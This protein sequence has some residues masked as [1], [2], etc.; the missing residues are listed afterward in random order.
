[1]TVPNDHCLQQDGHISLCT[2]PCL[3]CHTS[4]DQAA[5][6]PQTCTQALHRLCKAVAVA[7]FQ[8]QHAVA[9]SALLLLDSAPANDV[10]ACV[11]GQCPSP[12]GPGA[13]CTLCVLCCKAKAGEADRT[14]GRACTV[15]PCAAAGLIVG[16]LCWRFGKGGP[17]CPG[18]MHAALA[19]GLSRPA[20]MG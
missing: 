11:H 16:L 5:V 19:P 17:W 12:A 18:F 9:C 3:P 10:H 15:R 20:Q 14:T 7:P 8:A 6:R 13:A 4:T 1:M 2:L